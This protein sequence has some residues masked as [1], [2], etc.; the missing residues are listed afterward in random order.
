LTT[1]PAGTKINGDT[2]TIPG[3]LGSVTFHPYSDF[4]MH[5]VGTGDGILQITPEHYGKRV[6]ERMS[7]YMAKQDIESSRNKMRTAPLWGVRLR[8]RLMHDGESI[9]LREAIRRHQGEA[10]EASRRFEKL[11]KDD[12]DAVIEFLKSL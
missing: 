1:A 2:Y 6:F 10:S 11:K 3:A 12:Q 9:T 8:P 7:G 4:L 5:D